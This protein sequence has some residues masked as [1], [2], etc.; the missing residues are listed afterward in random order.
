MKV[1]KICND[2]LIVG[3]NWRESNKKIYNYKCTPCCLTYQKKANKVEYRKRKNV[4]YTWD[5][6][7]YVYVMNKYVGK[8]NIPYYR[9]RNH[10]AAGKNIDDFKIIGRFNN[11][12]DAL[13]VEAYFHNLG[14]EGKYKKRKYA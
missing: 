8:T 4:K 13:A 12:N 5:G 7:W 6:N 14:F 3:V 2:E 11:E 10:K 9:K 1:C